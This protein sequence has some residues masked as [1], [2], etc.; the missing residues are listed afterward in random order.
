[1]AQW[2]TNTI[3]IHVVRLRAGLTP[4][5]RKSRIYSQWWWWGV[6][7]WKITKRKPQG[8][9]G[10]LLNGPPKVLHAGRPV[11]RHHLVVEAEE[12]S[13]RGG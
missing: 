9:E 1:M 5:T 12:P 8:A 13:R 11:I 7:G 4:N 2:L 10:N 6:S 3:S